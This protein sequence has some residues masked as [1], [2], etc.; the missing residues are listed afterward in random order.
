MLKIFRQVAVSWELTALMTLAIDKPKPNTKQ[1]TQLVW[2]MWRSAFTTPLDPRL[3]ETKIS[4]NIPTKWVQGVF[5]DQRCRTFMWRDCGRIGGR[6]SGTPLPTPPLT[7]QL[8]SM[9]DHSSLSGPFLLANWWLLLWNR[10][11]SL[12]KKLGNRSLSLSQQKYSSCYETDSFLLAKRWPLLCNGSLSLRES[13]ASLWSIYK[14][15]TEY[16]HI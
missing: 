13:M 14:F 6:R 7:L 2:W 11:V 10:Y 8:H 3:K 1:Q 9:G 12:C 15:S 5:E 16:F 4:H